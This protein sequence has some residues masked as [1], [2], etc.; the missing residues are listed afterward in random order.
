MSEK[1]SQPKDRVKLN[2]ET[3]LQT[4]EGRSFLNQ[5]NQVGRVLAMKDSEVEFKG[6]EIAKTGFVSDCKSVQLFKCPNGYF[7][8]CNKTFSMNNWSAAGA[9]IDEILKQIDDEAI[10]SA[11]AEQV[12]QESDIAS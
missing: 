2:V 4:S 3:I 8:F 1:P 9:S 5:I 10:R 6:E 12:S 11:L 7:V